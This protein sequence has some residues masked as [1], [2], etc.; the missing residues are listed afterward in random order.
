M[1]DP[2]GMRLLLLLVVALA[3][4]PAA[5]ADDHPSQPNLNQP[6]PATVAAC[7]AEAAQ[8]GKDAFTAK[9]GPSEP[10]GHCYAAHAG[11]TT[12]TTTTPAPP[13]DPPAVAACK[14]EAAHLGT[15]AFV[16]KYGTPETM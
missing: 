1:A 7:Q 12:T 3:A 9:Y 13:Q 16:A 6:G 14:A 10:F 8:L 11:T 5:L 2:P 15:A 4:V